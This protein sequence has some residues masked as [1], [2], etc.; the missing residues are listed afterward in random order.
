MSDSTSSDAVVI[1]RT[2]K[3]PVEVIWRMW[4]KSEDFRGWYGPKGVSVPVAQLDVRVGGQRLV[5][6]EM[7]TAEGRHQMWTVGQHLEVV[8]NQRLVY[9][10]DP[11]DEHGNVVDMPGT[12]GEGIP[13]S[14]KVI[15]TFKDLGGSTHLVL[16]H[17]GIPADSPGQMGWEQA[18]D[19]L[20]ANLA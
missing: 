5:C 18:L 12:D 9:T 11:S 2:L 17:E 4:T 13:K 10:E 8:P 16:R 14:T 20:A 6:M 3:A 1:E 7:D 19:K 15:V